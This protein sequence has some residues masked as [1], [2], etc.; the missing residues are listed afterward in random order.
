MSRLAS[1][2]VLNEQLQRNLEETKRETQG[3][4][5]QEKLKIPLIAHIATFL[6]LC[7]GVLSVTSFKMM[8]AKYKFKHGIF[9]VFLMFFGEWVNLLIFGGRMAYKDNLSTSLKSMQL[10]CTVTK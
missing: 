10:E 1:S 2:S 5:N 6:M 3:P 8:G 7:S 9:Q 4:K